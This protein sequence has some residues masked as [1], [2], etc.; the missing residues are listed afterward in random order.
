V[1]DSQLV[2]VVIPAY[3][4]A[5]TLDETLRSVRSQTH[6]ALEIIVVDDGSTDSTRLVAEQHAARDSRVRVV[7]QDNAGVAAARN[8]GWRRARADLIAFVDADDLWAPTKIERQ[9]RALRE[10]GPQV[11]LVYCWYVRIGGDSQFHRAFEG[12]RHE[13]DVLGRLIGWNFIGNGSSAL[14]R[15]QALEYA[16]GFDSRLRAAGAEGCE[17]RLFYCRVAKKYH[18]AVVPEHLTG[19]RRLPDNMSSNRPRMLRS[20]LLVDDELLASCPE[21]GG[22]LRSALRNYCR[23]LVNDALSSNALGQ[24][25]PL[26]G[27]MARRSPTLAIDVLLTDLRQ[28]IQDRIRGRLRSLIGGGASSAT[29]WRTQR[30][31]VGEPD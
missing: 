9:L 3:N 12:A 23:W 31:L 20:W 27:V 16:E 5:L 29:E 25:A 1:T 4:A 24:L 19:Y 26:L 22:A 14:V 15:K 11:G 10:A 2:S 8:S 17:D 30:F 6:R 18:Y 7:T 13:G 21:H 28:G